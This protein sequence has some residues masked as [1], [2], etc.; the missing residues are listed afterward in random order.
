MT[1]FKSCVFLLF[2]F[3]TTAVLGTWQHEEETFGSSA[4]RILNSN[5]KEITQ[6]TLNNNNSMSFTIDE[7]WRTIRN[8]R[9]SNFLHYIQANT[10]ENIPLAFI[11]AVGFIAILLQSQN[12]ST[13]DQLGVSLNN[14]ELNSYESNNSNSLTLALTRG[15]SSGLITLSLTEMDKGDIHVYIAYG[16]NSWSYTIYPGNQI[17]S[18][19]LS[20]TDTEDDGDDGNHKKLKTGTA[21][22]RSLLCFCRQDASHDEELRD[23]ATNTGS[24]H[25]F[26]NQPLSNHENACFL[27]DD[28]HLLSLMFTVSQ[29]FLIYATSSTSIPQ[30][31]YPY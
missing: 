5:G 29:A 23:S 3:T 13:D 22:L 28:Q 7:R 18:K 14:F 27:S 19:T 16:S 20:G 30:K 10:P 26:S 2:Y 11:G 21:T 9:S 6:F 15:R 8:P 31:F 1:L 25:T 12:A 17:S 24:Y 4:F